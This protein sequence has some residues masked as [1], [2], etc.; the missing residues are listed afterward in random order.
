[1]SRSLGLGLAIALACQPARADD[2]P[3]VF[4]GDPDLGMEGGV[5]TIRSAARLVFGYDAYASG[6]LAFDAASVTDHVL[7]VGGR[8]L[9]TLL[10]DL[11]IDS[12]ADVFIHEVFGHGARG[13][14]AGARPQFTFAIPLP[15]FWLFHQTGF[16]GFTANTGSTSSDRNVAGTA[17]GLEAEYD[18]AFWLNADLMRAG[19]IM[20]YSDS[21]A[22]VLS[23]VG[24][25]SRF[26]GLAKASQDAGSDPDQYV[27]ELQVD[28]NR[29]DDRHHIVR[30]LQEA[31]IFNF[32]DPT[33]A[34]AT[35]HLL[36]TYL[37]RG[38]RDAPF[39]AIRAGAFRLYP[40]TRFNLSP[41]GAE[42]YLDLFASRGRD[43]FDAY[44]RF[45]S[46]GLAEDRG[47]G[48]RAFDVAVGRDLSLGGDLDVWAQR[49]LI[50]APRFVFDR[51][52]RLG[53]GASASVEWR[54]HGRLG[55][56]AK[57]GYKSSGYLMA[58]PLDAGFY[59]YL[60]IAL[61]DRS[62]AAKSNPF[63]SED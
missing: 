54:L 13:R 5:R 44:V 18:A 8:A 45:T 20:H 41:F 1:M 34:L 55:V 11:P 40:A 33:L 6:W 48:V 24:Y 28:Y 10:V 21:L 56:T 52:N 62:T 19:G 39:P 23:K 26:T 51:A 38:E 57:L 17:A 7:A 27:T 42:H 61:Y 25:F 31:Y 15:Y 16:E 32:A 35:Y 14:E 36:Y 63:R 60:G 30:R 12:A 49:E 43:T 59:G 50:F 37:F 53:A 58:Q 22:Y 29:P 9:K 2:A 46:S 3:L 4:V 47:L